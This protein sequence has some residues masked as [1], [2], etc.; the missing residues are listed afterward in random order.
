MNELREIAFQH[1]PQVIAVTESWGRPDIDD[2]TFKID[3]YI[4]YRSDK[5]NRASSDA[6][7]TLLYVTDKLGQRE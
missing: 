5:I 3:G 2:I 1:K 4:M 6:G 7:G